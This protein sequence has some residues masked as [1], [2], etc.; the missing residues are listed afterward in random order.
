MNKRR[1]LPIVLDKADRRVKA[2]S[3][4]EFHAL[5]VVQQMMDDIALRA[6]VRTLF[7]DK[8]PAKRGFYQKTV[9]I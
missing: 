6:Y 1:V 9:L 7:F 2:E 3:S 5:P 8:S 4:V